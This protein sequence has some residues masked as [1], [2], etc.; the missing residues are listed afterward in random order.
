MNGI[1]NIA[2]VFAARPTIEGAGVH[3]KRA[4]GY[5]QVPRLDPFLL[6][7]DFHSDVPKEYLPGFPLAPSPG[8]RDHHLRV[9]WKSGARR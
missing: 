8:D 2:R 7:D 5:A 4:L 9:A 3:L 6:L 1:R